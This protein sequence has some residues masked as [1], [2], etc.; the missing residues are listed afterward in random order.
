MTAVKAYFNGTV[1]VP[2]NPVNVKLNQNVIV[3]ILED[4]KSGFPKSLDKYI[5]KLSNSDCD[6]IT[7]ALL[8]T[9]MVD[10]DEW[11]LG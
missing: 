3:T 1:F 4:S 8:D 7:E 10:E 6:E 9:Q 11:Q 2:V 5:G